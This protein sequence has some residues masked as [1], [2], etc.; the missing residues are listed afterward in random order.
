MHYRKLFRWGLLLLLFL[1][2]SA[3]LV[4]ADAAL[5]SKFT[6]TDLYNP[7]IKIDQSN[8]SI[9]RF[10]T[11]NA[12]IPP[13]IASKIYNASIKIYVNGADMTLYLKRTARSDKSIALTY[14]PIKELPAGKVNILLKASGSDNNVYSQN[15]SFTVNPA[16]DKAIAPYYRQV[17]ANP[18]SAQAHINLARAYETRKTPMLK[19]AAFEYRYALV[20]SPKN[21]IAMQGWK[22]VFAELDRKSVTIKDKFRG[23]G[24]TVDVSTY[25]PV[26]KN[27]YIPGI[28]SG[29]GKGV[30]LVDNLVFFDVRVINNSPEIVKFD[31]ADTLLI[32]DNDY[33]LRPLAVSLS[34]YPGTI[35]KNNPKVPDKFKRFATTKHYLDYKAGS[36]TLIAKEDIQPSIAIDGFLVYELRYPRFKN[37]DLWIKVK[38]GPKIKVT[39]RLP[40]I[41]K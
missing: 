24:V 12:A 38:T 11:L 32:V 14:D 41:K 25:D 34:D 2:L 13:E 20:Y 31:P 39:Y 37:L 27:V 18:R 4:F 5:G 6:I 21:K 36:L 9:S 3:N 40:F 33:Q 15:I 30:S 26:I 17:Q 29:T 1:L 7:S 22:R 35:L 8:P 23:N 10:A 28:P 19:D 16:A